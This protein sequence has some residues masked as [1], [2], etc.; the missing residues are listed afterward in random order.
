MLWGPG[1]VTAATD[2]V[3]EGSP[4]AASA[5]LGQSSRKSWRTQIV[6]SVEDTLIAVGPPRQFE[7]VRG[8]TRRT[9]VSEQ[10]KFAARWPRQY[11][12]VRKS[13]RRVR[14]SNT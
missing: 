10:M 3:E 5:E 14:R 7:D 11:L 13:A 9:K 6:P 1:S 2:F 12:Y 4:V 8:L